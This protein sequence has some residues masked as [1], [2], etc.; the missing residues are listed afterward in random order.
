VSQEDCR[1]LGE[2]G[3]CLGRYTGFGCIGDRCQDPTRGPRA[4][5]CKWGRADGYCSKHRKFEC[6]GEDCPEYDA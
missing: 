1:H 6:K 3:K 2:D 4:A 5:G